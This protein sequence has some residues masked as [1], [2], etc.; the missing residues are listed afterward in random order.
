[1]KQNKTK[2][3]NRQR[4]LHEDLGSSPKKLIRNKQ[5]KAKTN[6]VF[7]SMQYSEWCNV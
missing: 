6:G 2:W 7:K 1:M 4:F 3:N 5:E